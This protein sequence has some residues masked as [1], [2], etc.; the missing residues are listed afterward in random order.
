MGDLA[1]IV[2]GLAFGLSGYLVS[3]AGFLSINATAAWLPWVLLGVYKM[4]IEKRKATLETAFYL[5]MLLLAGHA[6]IAW[7][8]LLL[9]GMWSGY[10]GWVLIKRSH[11]E[12]GGNLAHENNWDQLQNRAIGVLRNWIKLALAVGFGLA[13]AAIQLL[14][15]AELLLQSQRE[16]GADIDFVMTYSFWPWRFLGYI[17]P[18]L[19]GTPASG[20]YW[21]YANFWEDAVYI[22]L[23]PL[24]LAIQ[25]VI[26][27]TS[28]RIVPRSLVI[29]VLILLVF[30]YILALGRNTPVFPWLY[31]NIPTFNLFQAPS[32]YT[33]WATFGLA[34]LAGLGAEG[35]QRPVGVRG[36]GRTNRWLVGTLAVVL[37]AV[38]ANFLPLDIEPSIIRSTA[39]AGILGVGVG[40]LTLFAPEPAHRRTKPMWTW[41]VITFV[42][43][44]LL[45]AGW[46]LNPGIDLGFYGGESQSA[47]QVRDL[48]GGGRIFLSDSDEYELT[49]ERYF[50]FDSFDGDWETLRAS[51]LPNLNILDRLPSANNFDPLLPDRYV[52]WM[53][54]LKR[55]DPETREKMLNQIGVNVVER[56]DDTSPTGL[57]FDY[58]A[59]KSRFR[60]APCARSVGSAQEALDAVMD[61]GAVEYPDV[62][63]IEGLPPESALICNGDDIP[64]ENANITLIG[65]TPNNVRVQVQTESPGWLVLAD[66]WYP[67]WR[68]HVDGTTAEM[69]QADYLF[70]AVSIPPGTHQVI[71]SYKPLVFYMGFLVSLVAWPGLFYGWLR[72]KHHA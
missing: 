60:W 29:G 46:G 16:G 18:H 28:K 52:S 49:F 17:A 22:G 12:E 59:G 27:K 33:I 25:A 6:Q 47:A 72:V 56:I 50:R 65:E 11:F 57:V 1:Q 67:G 71:F 32:R 43:L 41:V 38:A 19:F 26:R 24:V 13:L 69:F 36:R 51:L 42:T 68:A 5:S 2:S 23:L 70:R 37:A 39:L 66:T 40:V 53:N 62:V 48:L 10:W 44:D 55:A 64:E 14:P 9:A 21:G 54:A 3:R 30:T 61:I 45:A 7:Y 20:D 58:V 35:W 15:T 34:L 4:A 31:R 8:T 63:T